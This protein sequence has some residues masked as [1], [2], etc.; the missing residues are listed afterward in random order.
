MKQLH[1]AHMV[2]L[3]MLFLVGIYL[4]SIH[5]ALY[6]QRDFIPLSWTTTNGGLLSTWGWSQHYQRIAAIWAGLTFLSTVWV[7][8]RS[9]TFSKLSKGL[10]GAGGVGAF[11]MAIL[12]LFPDHLALHYVFLGWLVY[13]TGGMMCSSYLLLQNTMI[14]TVVKT[15]E[16]LLDDQWESFQS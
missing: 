10:M 8:Y 2:L 12:L 13:I 5:D 4:L 7:G 9:T 14:T 3:L 6:H 1:Q 15:D 11:W 16:T